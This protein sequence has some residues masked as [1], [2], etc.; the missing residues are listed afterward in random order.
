MA[1]SAQLVFGVD[2]DTMESVVLEL[3]PPARADAGH[4]GV[5]H[6]RFG[7][8]AADRHRGRQRRVPRLD[9]QLRHRGQTSLLGVG[10]GP[11]VSESAA[12]QMADGVRDA[13]GADVALSLT[14]VAG[15]AEQDGQPVGTLFVGLVGPASTR[16]A[17]PACPANASRCAS[18]LSSHRSASCANICRS[19]E[20]TQP[21]RNHH[22]SQRGRRPRA[23]RGDGCVPGR[24]CRRRRGHHV[25][26]V[27]D[28]DHHH[29]HHVDDL[30]DGAGD[31]HDGGRAGHRQ[32]RCRPGGR[33]RSGGPTCGS[34][35]L[36][37]ARPTR[38]IVWTQTSGPDVTAGAGRSRDPRPRS[39][40][41]TT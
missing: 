20:R 22:R 15:P 14:G 18:S 16:S 39:P 36:R 17:S 7:G 5:G 19:H 28:I 38:S 12:R 30:D 9:R 2:D 24:A 25:D 13:L 21:S 26:D 3:L 31:D 41:R 40:R 6:G 35:H 29:L 37:P 23:A 27:D 33:S 8:G 34:R 4:G 11:V 1:S 10:D 32:R